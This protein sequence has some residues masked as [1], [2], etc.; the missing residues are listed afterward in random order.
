MLPNLLWVLILIKANFSFGSDSFS[1]LQFVNETSSVVAFRSFHGL[2]LGISN[3]DISGHQEDVFE[4]TAYYDDF[5]PTRNAIFETVS[6]AQQSDPTEIRQI[7]RFQDR[8]LGLWENKV[9]FYPAEHFNSSRSSLI[10]EIHSEIVGT[11]TFSL[12]T[13]RGHFMSI[14]NEGNV[15]A[16]AGD[17]LSEPS[18]DETFLWDSEE[19]Y[20]HLQRLREEGYTVI[21]VLT[22]DTA[23]HVKSLVHQLEQQG[24]GM[25]NGYQI[26]IPD[27]GVHHPLFGELLVNLQALPPPPPPPFPASHV[28]AARPVTLQS[29]CGAGGRRCCRWCGECECVGV[30]D[31][32]TQVLSV[33]RG[34]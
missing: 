8:I 23:F 10:F 7:I 25:S 9:A 15:R 19:T 1:C 16:K 17:E 22:A 14:D 26:R 12:K 31:W 32:G 27:V 11:E 2:N 24:R 34:A 29:G 4:V 6:M 3:S 21:K 30:W 18:M 13:S 20:E 28:T 33:V 5:D